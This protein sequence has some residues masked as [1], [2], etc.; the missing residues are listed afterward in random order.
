MTILFQ[1]EIITNVLVSSI[2]FIRIPMLWV[3]GH[4]EYV[5]SFSAGTVFIRQDL[6][7]KDG[8]ALKGPSTNYIIYGKNAD[9][10]S[11]DFN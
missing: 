3:Y 5:Y 11:A 1:F 8:P 7:Y 9:I 10:I 4:Y 6:T 2:C